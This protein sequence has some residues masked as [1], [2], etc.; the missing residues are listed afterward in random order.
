MAFVIEGTACWTAVPDLPR[1]SS[2]CSTPPADLARAQ[3][4]AAHH[5]DCCQARPSTY[6]SLVYGKLLAKDLGKDEVLYHQRDFH[7]AGLDAR[8]VAMLAY[9]EQVARNASRYTK[10]IFARPC[11]PRGWGDR[12]SARSPSAPPSVAS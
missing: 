12:R 6:C 11:A 5:P 8:D 1:W 7:S 9:A 2:T 10:W 3:G 4:L